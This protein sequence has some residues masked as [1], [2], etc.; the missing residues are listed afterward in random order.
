M[1]KNFSDL[2]QVKYLSSKDIK[3]QEI[4]DKQSAIAATL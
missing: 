4:E 2:D 3:N 1:Y